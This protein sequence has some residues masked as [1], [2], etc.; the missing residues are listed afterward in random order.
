M[1]VLWNMGEKSKKKKKKKGGIY[2]NFAAIVGS[3]NNL[4]QTANRING[5]YA[6]RLVEVFELLANA[7]TGEAEAL[8][9]LIR[10]TAPD[11]WEELAVELTGGLARKKLGLPTP[12]NAFARKMKEDLPGF[13]LALLSKLS[14]EEWARLLENKD[15]AEALLKRAITIVSKDPRAFA[16]RL[17]LSLSDDNWAKLLED[18]EVKA[19]ILKQAAKA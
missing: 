6:Q 2:A 3:A 4:L 8:A 14:E 16:K 12:E 13:V 11:A 18:E 9:A 1:F 5:E 7:K 10:A 19:I 17:L 15:I